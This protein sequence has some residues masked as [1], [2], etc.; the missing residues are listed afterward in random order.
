MRILRRADEIYI[1]KRLAAIYYIATHWN[2][3]DIEFMEKVITNVA[4]IAYRIGGMRM[5]NEVPLF[6]QKIEEKCKRCAERN[7]NETI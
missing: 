6:K 7:P 2:V 5:M 3:E 1:T 4:D